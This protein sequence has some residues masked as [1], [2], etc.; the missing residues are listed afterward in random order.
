MVTE[1]RRRSSREGIGRLTHI[2]VA[3]LDQESNAFAVDFAFT[4]GL[5]QAVPDLA[6]I[7]QQLSVP[8]PAPAVRMDHDGRVW[9]MAGDCLEYRQ[10]RKC[11]RHSRTGIPVQ[12]TGG[13]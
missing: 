3:V 2:V 1:R 6:Y 11:R 8:E 7:A 10:S 4:R 12:T 13:E 5:I 9:V